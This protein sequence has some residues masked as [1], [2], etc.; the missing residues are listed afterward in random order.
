MIL[1]KPLTNEDIRD[2]VLSKL[3][4]KL[5]D[6]GGNFTL[7]DFIGKRLLAYPIKS[8]KEGIYVLGNMEVSQSR[9]NELRDFLNLQTDVIRFLIIKKD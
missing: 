9:V 7:V 3:E 1:A 2:R 4:K 5:V 6:F 8:F